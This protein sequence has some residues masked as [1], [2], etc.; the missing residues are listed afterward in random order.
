VTERADLG[1]FQLY[2][3]PVALA[4]TLSLHVFARSYVGDLLHF[5]RGRSW[6]AGNR[7]DQKHAGPR[8]RLEG[9]PVPVL[10]G[11]GRLSIVARGKDGTLVHHRSAPTGK[12]VGEDV[13]C[14]GGARLRGDPVAVRG[15]DALHVFGATTAG[16][17]LH[18]R[19]DRYGWAGANLTAT[20]ESGP[21]LRLAGGPVLLSKDGVI[22]VFGRDPESWLVHLTLEDGRWTAER[23]MA[24]IAADPVATTGP[25][26]IHAFA[27][28]ADGGL[29]HAWTGTDRWRT[30]DV[31]ST[32]AELAD[33]AAL[34]SGLTAWGSASELRLFG[35]GPGG[36]LLFRWRPD[37]DWTLRTIEEHAGVDERHR[38]ADDPIA[39]RTADGPHLFGTDGRG[40]ILHVEP[41]AW[42]EPEGPA[43]R[44]PAP[45]Q[46][47][48]P[49]VARS[50]KADASPARAVETSA[51][52]GL[53]LLGEADD[54]PP[55]AAEEPAAEAPDA[56]GATPVET[57][58]FDWE[59][60]RD[61]S[62]PAEVE[63][64]PMDLTMLD[65][66][67]PAPRSMQKPR[68]DPKPRDDKERK[69]I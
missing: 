32:R 5:R 41:G 11:P 42:T 44:V 51:A 21:E 61:K 66:W 50:K 48:R 43:A 25:A 9:D 28:S 39:V 65:T 38:P 59:T 18:W 45:A 24:G 16:E 14:P 20:R 37:C 33:R 19:R 67:P 34:E 47:P 23:I 3:D 8:F 53:P 58:G 60:V 27:M 29:V 64:E 40:T 36:L 54:T 49:P 62:Q 26:G 68:N 30:E 22:H 31:V 17:I 2:S 46:A 15:D 35:R 69:A 57:D 56:G 7:T 1:G 13:P 55:R 63:V 52:A 12:W 4:T 10:V 6:S